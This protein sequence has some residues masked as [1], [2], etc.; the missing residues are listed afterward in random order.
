MT[1]PSQP[2]RS[3]SLLADAWR[4]LKRNRLAVAGLV[5]IG[6]VAVAGYGAPIWAR[7]VTHFDPDHDAPEYLKYQAPGVRAPAKVF[8]TYD[9]DDAAFD[10][11]D[12][13]G[14]GFL[15]C[16][17]V[18]TPNV[19]PVGF[20]QLEDL[21]PVLY[22]EALA[23]WEA[24]DQRLGVKRLVSIAVGRLECP[25]LEIGATIA[26]FLENLVTS[27]DKARGTDT[28]VPGVVAR[29]GY[30]TWAEFPHDDGALPEE[31]RGYGLAGPDAFRAL[32]LDGDNVLTLPELTERARYFAYQSLGPDGLSFERFVVDHDRDRDLR[33]AR[34]EFPGAP[35]LHTMAF[36]SDAAGR[37]VLTRLLYGAR[38]SISVGL[39]AT[40][41]SLLI[42]VTW[43]AIAGYAGG[44]TDEIMMRIVDTLY[45]LPFMF[46][47][48]LL[49]VMFGKNVVVLFIA[50]G[51][52]QWLSMARV[53]RGQVMSLKH[54]EF[55][56][57]ARAI[58]ASNRA[59]I[60]RH[61]V[62]NV[63]GPVVVYSTLLVPAVIMEE[64]FLSFLGLLGDEISWGKMI[65]EALEIWQNNPGAYPWLIIFPGAALALTLFA[66]NFFG[67]GTRDAIDVKQ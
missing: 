64:A 39:L 9:G 17:R 20:K 43:G 27:Y 6:L 14:D 33:I 15:T 25:E 5:F 50:L 37:D 41:V 65:S 34:G 47:V 3:R 52:V 58:G 48:I 7:L 29:D 8:P 31:L 67:D 51:A 36:G 22:R 1:A 12:L 57:A 21:S 4:R 35:E 28:P 59:I 56:E 23:R 54:Q 61:L 63:V 44:R 19:L 62:R 26:A 13:D 24:L 55:V 45:G 18:P 66:M 49:M 40:L 53:V 38:L 16:R 60:F 42:G 11:I 2:E 10:V 30:V 32:D 46:L